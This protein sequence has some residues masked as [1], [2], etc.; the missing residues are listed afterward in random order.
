MKTKYGNFGVSL[1]LMALGAAGYALWQKLEPSSGS[2]A[3]RKVLFYQDSMHP[4]IKSDQ[5][6]KCT[7]CAMDLTPIHEGEQAVG[8][9]DDVVVLSS[10]SVTVLNVQTE[11]VARRPLGLTLRAAGTLE[12][13]ETLKTVLAAPAAGR[14]EVLN[15]EYAGVEVAAG[16]PLLTMYS[17]ELALEKR[18]YLVRSRMS[19][20]RDPYQA[21]PTSPMDLARVSVE[22][23]PYFHDLVAPQSGTVIERNIYAGQYVAEGER[24]MTIVDSSVLW[25]RFDVYENQLA[26]VV[27]GQTLE[28]TV[29][30]V[31]G[32]VFPA[33][34]SFIEPALD[35]TT[36]TVKVRA[37]IKNPPVEVSGGQTMRLL[38][39]GMYADGRIHAELPGV[40]TVARSAV[41]Q[42]G[43]RAYA[44]VDKGSG[45]YE[46]RRVHLG[47]RGDRWC[48]VLN[49]LTEGDRV[50]TAGNVLI[51]AQAEFLRGDESLEDDEAAAGP[52]LA[53]GA[54]SRPGTVVLDE[55]QQAALATFL[56]AA[57]SIAEALAA[58]D[59]GHARQ[60]VAGLPAALPA[61]RTAFPEP[62]PWHEA[63]EAIDGAGRGLGAADLESARRA[64]LPF[65]TAVVGLVQ[66]A[67]ALPGSFHAVKVYYCPMAPEPGLWFQ[68]AGPLKNPYFGSKMLHCGEEVPPPVLAAT[69]AKTPAAPVAPAAPKTMG[70]MQPHQTMH[71]PKPPQVAPMKKTMQ[72]ASAPAQ[73]AN[74]DTLAAPMPMLPQEAGPS[75]RSG[76][77][78]V[79][80]AFWQR[81]SELYASTRTENAATNAETHPSLAAGMD[82]EHTMAKAQAPAGTPEVADTVGG[83]ETDAA[84]S[85]EAFLGAA[86]E[87]SAALAADD[88]EACNRGVAALA[89]R[90][91]AMQTRFAAPHRFSTL[92][93]R[94]SVWTAAPPAKDLQEA[95]QRFLPM[96]T[97][98]VEL[99]RQARGSNPNLADLK[100]YHCSMAPQPGLWV[101]AKGPLR[102]PYYGSKMLTCGEEVEP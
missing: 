101:Q 81:A 11:I 85:L 23:D 76:R 102:N 78:S 33:V 71:S 57:H 41:L 22:S 94:M 10:N 92:F 24:L 69:A 4:W 82:P 59:L 93:R 26:W 75:I 54:E 21:T 79:G 52:S 86:A 62:H 72:S 27:P 66:R 58:D 46:R 7:I 65:S 55:G 44:Y 29:P 100:I 3:G 13:N 64:F 96:S 30:A 31:Q 98:V 77:R 38:R 53:D 35:T 15:V 2:A 51:D 80:M 60:H 14:I 8:M 36:R 83:A 49:G 88:L 40:L 34:V 63:V 6:G 1:L 74:P 91:P 39:Y 45:A 50:V 42:P 67:R 25:F 56:K 20:Q 99:T 9:R 68:S 19:T 18:R 47:R 28:V 17:P 84:E 16:Q 90:L 43:T 12:A 61:L 95:R 32:K 73:K 97:Q 5:P 89:E 37:D 87:V 70:K 48:E